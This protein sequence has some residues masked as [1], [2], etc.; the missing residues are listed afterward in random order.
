LEEVKR[1]AERQ[2]ILQA[3]AMCSNNKSETAK[4]LKIPRPLL[5]QKMKRLGIEQ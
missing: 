2:A 5:Y 4:L 3:L 1:Q